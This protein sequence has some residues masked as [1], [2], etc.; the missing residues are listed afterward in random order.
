MISCSW[1]PG[2]FLGR[3]GSAARAISAMGAGVGCG[4]PPL[5]PRELSCVS[6]SMKG[7]SFSFLTGS[8][9]APLAI[10]SD[11]AIEFRIGFKRLSLARPKSSEA[12]RPQTAHS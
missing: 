1:L 9:F 3:L 10:D 8:E 5:L 7:R 4:V 2:K 6:S 11:A 12:Q